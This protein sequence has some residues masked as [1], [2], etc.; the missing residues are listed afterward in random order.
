MGLARTPKEAVLRRFGLPQFG[1]AMEFLKVLGED[2]GWKSK[3]GHPLESDR[4]AI[5]FLTELADQKQGFLYACAPPATEELLAGEKSVWAKAPGGPGLLTHPAVRP[6]LEQH[7][8]GF[9][10]QAD[11]PGSSGLLEMASIALN[12]EAPAEPETEDEDSDD[13]DSD[14]DEDEDEGEDEEED[15]DDDD[16]EEEDDDEDMEEDE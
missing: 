16:D 13:E 6:I 9:S 11:A 4:I 15:E 5:K 10:G 1:D 7:F 3:R 2:K 14:M 12:F 8:S